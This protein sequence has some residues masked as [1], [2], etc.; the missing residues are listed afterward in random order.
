LN[1]SNAA[2][3]VEKL[4]SIKMQFFKNREVLMAAIISCNKIWF[5]LRGY[6]SNR[7]EYPL[8][9]NDNSYPKNSKNT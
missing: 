5:I 6:F 2:F 4:K 1:Q 7:E 3:L 9:I 8:S